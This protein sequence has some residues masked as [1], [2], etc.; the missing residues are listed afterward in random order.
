M[1]QEF[2]TAEMI[3]ILM[4]KSWFI[5]FAFIEHSLRWE[6]Q[7]LPADEIEENPYGLQFLIFNI[8]FD[9]DKLPT[10]VVDQHR[11]NAY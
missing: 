3:K 11:I 1:P 8:G 6:N 4:E 5:T 9:D 2:L 10:Y 7:F